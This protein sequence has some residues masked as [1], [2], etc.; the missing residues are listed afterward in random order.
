LRP[1][2]QQENQQAMAKSQAGAD[3]VTLYWHFMDFLWLYLFVLLFFI[4]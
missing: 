1:R 4:R 3:A 2:P